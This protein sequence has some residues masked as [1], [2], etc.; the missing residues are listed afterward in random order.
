MLSRESGHVFFLEAHC[1]L[2]PDT[3]GNHQFS[4][5]R[6]CPRRPN[7]IF[8]I[9]SELTKTYSNKGFSNCIGV[10]FAS[11]TA[12]AWLQQRELFP[13]NLS[14]RCGW[15]RP[16]FASGQRSERSAFRKRVRGWNEA[17]PLSGQRSS[18]QEERLITVWANRN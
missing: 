2:V 4:G 13:A 16:R 3:K 14:G 17:S 15:L 6:F 1:W 10:G 12:A 11:T 5:P 18:V 9:F 8:L 7:S